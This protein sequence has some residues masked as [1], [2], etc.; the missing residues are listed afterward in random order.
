MA[1]TDPDF[2]AFAYESHTKDD[3][4]GFTVATCE[5]RKS[6]LNKLAEFWNRQEG[7]HPL[8]ASDFTE[9]VIADFDAWLK[10]KKG[11]GP[12]TRRKALDILSIYIGRAI[13]RKVLP[14]HSNPLEYYDLPKAT[15]TKV[16]ITEDELSALEAVRLPP[17][18]HLARATYFIQYYLHGSRIGVV[19][20]L[21]WKHRAHGTVRFKMDKGEVEKVVKESP[22]LTALLDS[23]LPADGCAP[24]PEAY[25]LPWLVSRYEQLRPEK[26]LKEIKSATAAVNMNLKRVA[27]KVG[28]TA[29]LS[30]HTSRRALASDADDETKDLGIV[31]RLLGHTNRATTE[32]YTRGRDSRVVQDGAQQVYAR[33]PMPQLVPGPEE[34]SR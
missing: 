34:E 14:R 11:N 20:R 33:R 30:S 26:Q 17:K 1:P 7:K 28:I 19:L 8:G 10:R 32:K 22:Q 4:G 12:G 6:A 3:V 29:K 27:V 25:I 2:L 18:Q 24:D 16:W 31:Q 23:L 5:S 15:P 13:R 21:K 9:S